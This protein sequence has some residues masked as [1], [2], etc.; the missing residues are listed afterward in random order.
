M[1]DYLSNR[2]QR[3]KVDSTFS[4]SEEILFRVSILGRLLFII[5]LRDLLFVM[6]NTDFFIYGD[7]NTPYIIRKYME[8]VIQRFKRS[9]D[10]FEW[11][12]DNKIKRNTDKCHFICIS[13]QKANLTFENEEIAS[14]IPVDTFLSINHRFNIEIPRGKF[15]EISSIL[16]DESTWKL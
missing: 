3:I 14:N 11:F 13:N 4:S 1:Q 12:P 7:V 15:V 6:N 5:Y 16:K 10:L 9:K 2:K 8:D